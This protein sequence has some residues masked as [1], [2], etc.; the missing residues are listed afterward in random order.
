MTLAAI[1]IT[2][3]IS[4]LLIVPLFSTVDQI[5]GTRLK[6]IGSNLLDV[7]AEFTR[8]LNGR[9]S[10]CL[11]RRFGAAGTGIGKGLFELVALIC[12]G[13]VFAGLPFVGRF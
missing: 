11:R 2:F 5:A 1:I 9:T 3:G 10:A 8:F 13:F 12:L 6:E 7:G 4:T